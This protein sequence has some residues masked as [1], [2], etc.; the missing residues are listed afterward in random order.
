[1]KRERKREKKN[2]KKI[3]HF[4]FAF[5]FCLP[6]K[7]QTNQQVQSAENEKERERTKI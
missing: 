4:V 7:K 6:G 2:H 3:K 1:M 5:H